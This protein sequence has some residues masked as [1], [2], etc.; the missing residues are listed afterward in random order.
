MS[1]RKLTIIGSNAS[2]T[3][4]GIPNVPA[5]VDTGADSSSIWASN[6]TMTPDDKLQFSLFGPESPL[7]TGEK[8]TFEHYKV[9]R[10]RSSTGQ[11]TIRYR[12]KLPVVAA[13][14]KVNVNFTLYDRSSNNFP[15]LI[16]RKTLKNRFL[17]DVAQTETARPPK[18]DNSDLEAELAADPQKF[19]T[20]LYQLYED[21]S[22]NH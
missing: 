13:D 22:E 7:Y 15:V 20:K 12:I 4:A 14:K 1:K 10:V 21:S 9:Q 5:K 3:V 11:I 8:L 19:H 17:V 6:I 2:I 16:G 18:M